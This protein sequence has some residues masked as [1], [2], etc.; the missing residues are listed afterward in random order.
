MEKNNM[1]QQVEEILLEIK[2][3]NEQ[4]AALNQDINSLVQ[5]LQEKMK[6]IKT[7]QTSPQTFISRL[8]TTPVINPI[9]QTNLEISLNTIIMAD[10]IK[11]PKETIEAFERITKYY[12]YKSN[13]T[14]LRNGKTSRYPRYI[15]TENADPTIVK[16][17]L[18]FG[19]IDKIIVDDTLSS[20]SKLPSLLVESVEAMKESYGPGGTYG[21]QVFD[22]C[23]DLTGKPI[24]LCQIF[25]VK[26]DTTIE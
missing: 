5:T 11:Y 22:A 24:I 19:F 21:I 18:K 26:R 25:R 17:L 14:I 9:I 4:I 10:R 1:N 16:N 8:A 12:D 7:L 13:T 2:K 3:K 23:T 15:C 6:A 20:I